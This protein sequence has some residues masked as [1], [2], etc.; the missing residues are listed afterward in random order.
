MSEQEE[1]AKQVLVVGGGIGGITAA[2]ELA[3]CG[4]D[5]T[6]LE[7]GPSIGGRMIQ[8][9]KTFPTLDCSTCTLSPKMVEVA[10]QKKI[11][12]LSWAK[13]VAVRKEG[14]GFVVTILKKSRFVDIKKCTA[15]GSCWPGCPVVM[16]SE[17][18]MGTGPRKA[19]YIPFPQAIPNKASIDKREDRLC[20]AACVDACPIHTNVLGYL[21]H[22]SEGRFNDAYMLIRDTNPFPSAC[23][24]VCYAPCE[25]V[26][27]RGQMDDPLAIR[28][29]KRFA[30]DQFDLESLE[31]PQVQKTGRKVAVIGAGPAGL[32]CAHD[33][34]L[35]GHDVT[36]FEALPEPGGMLRY[37]IPEYRLP[38]AELRKEVGYIEKLGVVI[39]C[40]VEI[41]KDVTLEDIK[42]EYE[43]LFIGTGAP[44]GMLLG[45]EGED[46]SGVIDGIRFLR[47]VNSGETVSTGKN[48]AV[49]G[50]GNTAVDC[51]RTA[52]RVGG[53]SVTLIYRRTREEM[54][55]A[56]E[57]VEALLHEG[58]EIQFL[59]NPVRFHGENGMLSGVECIRMELGEPDES[60]RRRP[61]AVKGSE[62]KMP[63]DTVITALGQATQ[64]S[65]SSGLGVS[66]GKGDTI[67][68]DTTTGATN[69]EGVFAGGDVTTGPAYVVD[70]IAAGK[71]AARSIGK[72]LKGEEIAPENNA[73]KP[74]QLSEAELK[75]LSKRVAEA[76]RLSMPEEE[77]E[78]RIGNFSEVALGYAPED[79][80]K[81]ASRCL[82]GQ[83]VGCIQCGE[84][85]KRCEVK[86]V[87]YRMKDE[88]V[89]MQFDSIV[90]A[91]GF[92]LYDATERKEYGYG[93]LKGVVTGIEFER[94]CSVTGPTGGDILLN[95]KTPKRFYFIQCVGSRDRQSGARFCSRVCCMYT[96]KHASIVKDRIAGAEIYIS[97]IDVRAYG[98]NYEEFYKST[99]ESGTYYIRGIPGEVVQG[100]D[101]LLVRVEDMLSGEMKEVEVDL[102]VLATGVRPRK[103][104][105][106]LC[107]IMSVERDEYGFI[108]VSAIEPS[109]T[110]VDGIFV[111]GMASGPKDVPDTVASGG[112]AA[113]RCM[114]YISE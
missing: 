59:T 93:T 12:L 44:K 28:D 100:E 74:E 20:K 103:Q 1:K 105:E 83:I 48:V 8:L 60:G 23:G 31:P 113:S 22:I 99:Q 108:K 95:G 49:V 80:M 19:I 32:A 18:N 38:K 46:L 3:S 47:A 72:Y 33:C 56:D 101:G 76:T 21:K 63:V 62:F 16:K 94:M 9:D 6:M 27:N 15:C 57:E 112:E 13:P 24:R 81:E 43:A 98:K 25:R 92:D 87:D 53:E 106:E 107:S 75:E 90:L 52:K 68:V 17:F 29:L 11:D 73:G 91:P 97:Y 114:E 41:G 79:A 85:E 26:C 88:I 4:V 64:I 61:V 10:L 77:I 40:G 111:C 37:A 71:K 5:V 104:T 70:A 102:V 55:A 58:V 78:T 51:A 45:V 84:C 42:S 7:E 2:L 67:T 82:A 50:G 30:V 36:V 39:K 89:E 14:K 35:E 69:V 65:F 86:A 110:N 34:A 96:A 109:R 66:T 54:P